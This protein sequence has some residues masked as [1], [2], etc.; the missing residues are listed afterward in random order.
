MRVGG[1]RCFLCSPE[2]LPNKYVNYAA[3]IIKIILKRTFF[4]LKTP[5]R[6]CKDILQ[7]I[8]DFYKKSFA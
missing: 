3:S 2:N 4:L 1:R 6:V 7:G 8:F 5:E